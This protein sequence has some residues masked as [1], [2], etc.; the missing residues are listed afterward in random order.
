MITD[1]NHWSGVLELHGCG[2]VNDAGRELLF[3]S[4]MRPL[5]VMHGLRRGLWPD[6]L[7]STQK[8]RNRLGGV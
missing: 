3:Y 6:R 7:G 8:L 2:E 4:V 1:A 5:Y